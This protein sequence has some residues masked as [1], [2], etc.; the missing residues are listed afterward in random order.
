MRELVYWRPAVEQYLS[1]SGRTY[2]KGLRYDDLRRL[3]FDLET[4]GL[5]ERARP[6]LHDRPARQHRLAEPASTP[7]G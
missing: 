1:W 7:A 5:D 4:T 2:F 3:Q 6:D